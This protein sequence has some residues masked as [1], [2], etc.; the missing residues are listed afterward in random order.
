MDSFVFVDTSLQKWVG[1]V[2]TSLVYTV[3]ARC[4]CAFRLQG[5]PGG[6]SQPR[7][8]GNYPQQTIELTLFVC[9]GPRGQLVLHFTDYQ[10][11]SPLYRQLICQTSC[12]NCSPSPCNR[13]S[14]SQTTTGTPPAYRSSGP[15]SL[16]ISISL[17]QF[18]C[19][20]RTYWL[21]CRSQ[22]LSLLSASR[23]KRHG[24]TMFSP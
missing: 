11:S 21:G 10:R 24:L 17:P 22:S 20:T 19:R 14:L 15:H 16:S 4:I 12:L 7:L 3:N 6:F 2:H 18:T 1:G 23:Y 9:R 5:Y 13:F 8:I